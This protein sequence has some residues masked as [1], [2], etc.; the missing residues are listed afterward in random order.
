MVKG[1]LPEPVNGP[2]IGGTSGRGRVPKLSQKEMAA[3]GVEAASV[4]RGGVV[5]AQGGAC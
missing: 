2:G 5:A 4:V 3:G 1:F